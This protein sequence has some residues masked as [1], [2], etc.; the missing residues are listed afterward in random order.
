MVA[1]YHDTILLEAEPAERVVVY[2]LGLETVS[3]CG[4]VLIEE[5]SPSQVAG[6]ASAPSRLL[7]DPGHPPP[8]YRS[9]GSSSSGRAD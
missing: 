5:H 1:R 3:G 6:K 7:R 2:L 4:K 8:Q 9:S